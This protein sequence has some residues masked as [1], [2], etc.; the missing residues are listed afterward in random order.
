MNSEVYDVLNGQWKSTCK[1]LLGDEIGEL[2]HF[3]DY[4]LGMSGQVV[5]RKGEKGG[6][7]AFASGKYPKNARFASWQDI[8]FGN[9]TIA[10]SANDLKDFD[11]LTRW[12]GENAVYAGD[13]VLGNSKYIERSPNITDSFYVYE[14]QASANS[15]YVAYSGY[16]RFCES[17]F[18]SVMPGE[19]S[20]CI[21]CNDTYKVKRAFELWMSVC[22]SD[23]YYVFNL[24]DCS[25]CMFSFNL[26]SKR[27]AI[28]NVELPRGEYLKTKDSL[29]SQMR[30]ELVA[31]KKLPS[32][33]NLIM[34]CPDRT[35]EVRKEIS[36]KVLESAEEK[37]DFG[38]IDAA[39]SQTCSVLFGRGI[40]RLQEY[41]GWL[42]ENSRKGIVRKSAISGKRVF[43]GNYANYPSIPENRSVLEN[44]GIAIA[45]NVKPDADVRKASLENIP[46]IISKIAYLSLDYHDGMNHNI[47]DCFAYADSSNC[48][49]C[50]PCVQIKDSAYN[51]WPRSS[52]HL[53]GCSVVFDSSFCAR[54]SQSVK[55]TRCFEVDASRDCSDCYF[56]HNIEGCHECLFCFNAKSKRFA[57]GNAEYPKE[58]Y[59]K[60]KKLILAEIAEKLEKNK[61][62][63]YGIYNIGCKK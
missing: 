32:L 2:G 49:S 9:K 26:R 24:T 20:F 44:E 47:T 41:E 17:V 14:S 35:A 50:F 31:K 27:H 21:R 33:N 40:G 62:L 30:D 16:A 10:A 25:D 5:F 38:A 59:L 22:S 29:L 18:G 51:F 15:Q 55:L 34:Q 57:I 6:E 4:L 43:M 37:K 61:T 42:L 11:S 60:I 3:K 19:S 46:G 39:F 23:C 13:M 8:D 54:C 53:F 56:C 63:D 36:G 45:E 1:V 48:L 7:I 58:E 52:S 12:A 28:G